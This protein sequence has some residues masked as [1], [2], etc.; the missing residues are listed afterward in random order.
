MVLG[1][2]FMMGI[3]SYCDAVL[4]KYEMGEE[5]GLVLTLSIDN[6]WFSFFS[7]GKRRS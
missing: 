4:M 5:V 1:F 2:V 3:A 6:Y 7:G